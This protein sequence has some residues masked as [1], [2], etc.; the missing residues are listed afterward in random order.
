MVHREC[1]LES[2]RR[3]RAASGGFR[4]GSAAA[5]ASLATPAAS[6]AADIVKASAIATAARTSG[7]SNGEEII[8]AYRH[9]EG[10]TNAVR[11]YV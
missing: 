8:L 4:P 1:G 2:L 6:A 9:A 11:R 7:P 10:Y 3:T 5:S